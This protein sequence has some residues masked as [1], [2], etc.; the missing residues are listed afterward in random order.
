MNSKALQN[1]LCL[2]QA[3][4][5]HHVIAQQWPTREPALVL[6]L[7]VYGVWVEIVLAQLMDEAITA[8]F[9]TLSA[10]VV[11]ILMFSVLG[12]FSI[13]LNVMVMSSLPVLA[14]YASYK[15]PHITHAS[16]VKE[17]VYKKFFTFVQVR[18]D[19]PLPLH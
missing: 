6:N 11:I 1:W 7:H 15:S 12:T 19:V 14:V 16:S 10:G 17:Q 9:E 4:P 2:P 18:F 8:F 3:I 13:V 5:C